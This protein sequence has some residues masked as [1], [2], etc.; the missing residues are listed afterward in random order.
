MIHAVLIQ[1]LEVACQFF[2]NHTETLMLGA[3]L[4]NLT[5]LDAAFGKSRKMPKI[6]LTV[7]LQIASAGGASGV[8]NAVYSEKKTSWFT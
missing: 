4:D 3:G 8:T 1:S 7:E 2:K 5:G 6:C